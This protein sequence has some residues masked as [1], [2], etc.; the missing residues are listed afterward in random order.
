MGV[1]AVCK[2]LISRLVF[3]AFLVAAL[4]SFAAEG[5]LDDFAAAKKQAAEKGVPILVNFSGSDWCGWCIRLEREV[6]GEAE[7][8]KY[9]EENLVLFIADFPRRKEL[10]EVTAKQNRDL[11]EKSGV[12]GFPTILLLDAEGKELARTGYQ[13]GGPDAYV[14]HLKELLAGPKVEVQK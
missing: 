1:L 4:S 7:F 8:K 11:A 13:P 2:N 3:S 10:P 9:A 6:F 14:T 12:R 5:W